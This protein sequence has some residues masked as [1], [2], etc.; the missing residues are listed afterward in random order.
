MFSYYLNY[1]LKNDALGKP[2]KKI[3]H[4]YRELVPT[5]FLPLPPTLVGK[6]NI[7][8]VDQIRDPPLPLVVGTSYLFYQFGVKNRKK[9]ELR[10]I[11]SSPR[12][13]IGP[14]G[15]PKKNRD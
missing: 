14:T 6:L 9:L 15:C 2:S 12:Y 8:T 11:R 10:L 3:N 7:G 4:D 1:F 5:F 13:G